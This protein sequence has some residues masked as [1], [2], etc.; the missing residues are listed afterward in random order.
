MRHKTLLLFITTFCLAHGLVD[1]A[2]AAVLF[3]IDTHQSNLSNLYLF[4][5]IYD[6][7]AFFHAAL[8][9]PAGR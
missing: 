8:F 3:A 7:I 9:R 5:L 4:I 1:A 6:V 2:C